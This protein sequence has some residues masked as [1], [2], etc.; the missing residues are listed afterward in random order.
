MRVLGLGPG[1]SDLLEA[2]N[3]Q[4]SPEAPDVLLI[5]GVWGV[6]ELWENP[7]PVK[8][9]PGVVITVLEGEEAFKAACR[10]GSIP[11]P[12]DP[13]FVVL[14]VSRE[15]FLQT[16]QKASRNRP[17]WD[18]WLEG[19]AER[20][21]STWIHHCR[22]LRS[23][24]T[25]R[26]EFTRIDGILEDLLPGFQEG[27]RNGLRQVFG[28]QGATHESI[29]SVLGGSAMSAP[30]GSL[31]QGVPPVGGR[32][33]L[34][35]DDPEWRRR[36][37]DALTGYEVVDLWEEVRKAIV[38]NVLNLGGALDWQFILNE[39]GHAGPVNRQSVRRALEGRDLPQLVQLLNYSLEFVQREFVDKLRDLDLLIVDLNLRLSP[40]GGPD[41]GVDF[42][43]YLRH[44]QE[45][46]SLPVV[47]L[48]GYGGNLID[49]AREA[50]AN[51]Y[52]LKGPEFE[53][54]LQEKVAWLL[55]DYRLLVIDD[56]P[57]SVI[58]PDFA[59]FL[60]DRRT[61]YRLYES[62]SA[63]RQ[64]LE[65][66]YLRLDEFNLV[67]LDLRF[68]DRIVGP[69]LFTLLRGKRPDLPIFVVT[70]V[71]DDSVRV[72]MV[73]EHEG[74]N[75]AMDRYIRKPLGKEAFQA[76]RDAL[77]PATILLT[78]EG[79][80]VRIGNRQFSLEP[81]E[82]ALLHYLVSTGLPV[83][84]RGVEGQTIAERYPGQA[85]AYAWTRRLWGPN[86]LREVVSR[87]NG[88]ANRAA[89]RRLI[90]RS[91]TRG[92][93]EYRLALPA[94]C[95][96]CPKGSGYKIQRFPHSRGAVS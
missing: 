64:D 60:R 48:T 14:P 39:L 74:W 32:V 30:S 42:I 68:G 4:P 23:V 52:V 84:A 10:N 16:L 91:G 87:I 29:L 19:W 53:R 3:L 69:K 92:Q 86:T 94:I 93:S 54:I 33:G 57:Q 88:A 41:Q 71:D 37:Q 62:E 15:E 80:L 18:T 22:N 83:P 11:E 7:R 90:E 20:N 66:G 36:V 24:D 95:N 70:G 8:H 61:T 2:L 40:S 73:F 27:V 82:W 75:P 35:E 85:P 77:E 56:E 45:S 1:A 28:Q 65:M 81:R 55:A 46:S 49:R 26:D 12:P 47:V 78:R 9:R 76:L 63:L 17:P 51:A 50:G 5:V 96:C 67:L 31:P 58:T 21:W 44:R 38:N 43:G 34:I 59:Q 89:G 13:L 6:M 79:H 25:L 72:E